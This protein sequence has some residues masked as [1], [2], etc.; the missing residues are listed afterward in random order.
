MPKFGYWDCCKFRRYLLSYQK[1]TLTKYPIH[2]SILDRIVQVEFPTN[3]YYKVA[4]PKKQIVLHHTVSGGTARGDIAWW[5]Q[6]AS[7]IAT[8]LIINRDGTPYQCYSSRYWAHHL[9]VKQQVFQ[10]YGLPNSGSQNR[11]LNQQSVGIEIDSWGGLVERGGSWYNA[12]WNKA[13]RRYEA[14]N[15][16]IEDITEYPDG[17]RGFYAFEKYTDEQI[18]AVQELMEYWKGVYTD[19]P[20]AYNDDIWDVT[21]RALSGEPGVFA[22][23]S[24]RSDKSDCHPQPELIQMLR[25]L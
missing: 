6:T 14:G 21:T 24:Y 7:R 12:I 17:F 16:R 15:N 22:H 13:T 25:G 8:C 20:Y 9:G 2:M 10:N 19:I 23:V 1:K 5:L 18:Q 4:H 11:I 3:Q